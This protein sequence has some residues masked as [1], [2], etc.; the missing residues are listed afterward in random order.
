M[1]RSIFLRCLRG[2][3]AT[4]KL[5]GELPKLGIGLLFARI[6]F[7]PVDARQH[8]D[9]VAVEDGC[10]LV[11]GDAANRTG[12]VAADAGQ[13]KDGVEGLRKFTIW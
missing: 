10:G 4:N 6:G 12:G 2:L 3:R 7:D 1:R 9:D 13:G 5:L 8:T 11:E